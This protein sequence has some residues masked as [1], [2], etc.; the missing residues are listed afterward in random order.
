MLK[1]ILKTKLEKLENLKRAGMDT[2]PEKTERNF[3]NGEALDGFDKLTAKEIIL[4][5]R[6]R[7][8]RPMGNAAFAHIE[9]ES[10]KIQIFLS[11]KKTKRRWMF[12]TGKFYQNPSA[13]YRRSISESKTA[14]N[15]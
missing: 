8:F 9:D 1:D 5:G 12:R 3:Y 7:S 11:K 10:G 4:A 13:R 14:R 6:V 15:F 2:Y